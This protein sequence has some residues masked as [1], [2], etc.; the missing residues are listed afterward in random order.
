MGC[1]WVLRSI[2]IRYLEMRKCFGLTGGRE[3]EGILDQREKIKRANLAMRRKI[4]YDNQ[5]G[6]TPR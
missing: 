3:G 6:H 2:H 1:E 5:T 4:H